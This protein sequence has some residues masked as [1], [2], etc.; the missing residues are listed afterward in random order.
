MCFKGF[1][2]EKVIEKSSFQNYSHNKMITEI[3]VTLKGKKMSSV[4][5]N[6]FKLLFTFK[7]Q[8]RPKCWTY[9]RKAPVVSCNT[10]DHTK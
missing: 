1:D 10:E 9:Y 2:S 6:L 3:R 7:S 4:P 8:E 5:E